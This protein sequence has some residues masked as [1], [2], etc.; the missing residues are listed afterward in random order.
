MTS[1]TQPLVEYYR[2]SLS[3]IHD[4]LWILTEVTDAFF[5]NVTHAH[6]LETKHIHPNVQ[7]FYGCSVQQKSGKNN[8]V[9][10]G[11]ECDE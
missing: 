1:F 2:S 7:L 10:N 3:V 5:F 4:V 8:A 11:V 6:F 9:K